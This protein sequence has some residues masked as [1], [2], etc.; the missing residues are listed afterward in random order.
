MFW[1]IL[2]YAIVNLGQVIDQDALVKALQ[3][4]IIKAAALD[5]TYPEPLPRYQK[6][7]NIIKAKIQLRKSLHFMYIMLVLLKLI[8]FIC[9]M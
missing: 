4:G 2:N 9:I 7:Y 6:L 1:Q 5:V 3:N 8:F